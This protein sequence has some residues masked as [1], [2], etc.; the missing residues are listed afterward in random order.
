MRQALEATKKVVP[1]LNFEYFF[2]KYKY[3][4]SKGTKLG[5]IVVLTMYYYNRE[6]SKVPLEIRKKLPTVL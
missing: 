1:L 4:K 6:V 3:C 5:S 2:K